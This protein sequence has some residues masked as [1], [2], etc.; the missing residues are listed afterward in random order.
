MTRCASE[1]KKLYSYFS[2]HDNN[3]LIETNEICI[4]ILQ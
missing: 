3:I 2:C 4:C 1:F